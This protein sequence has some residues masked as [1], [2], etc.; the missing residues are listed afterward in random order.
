MNEAHKQYSL[1]HTLSNYMF[2]F[3]PPGISINKSRKLTDR[4]IVGFCLGLKYRY[5][6]GGVDNSRNWSDLGLMRQKD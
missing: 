4:R 2:H 6:P 3:G 1:L 5:F